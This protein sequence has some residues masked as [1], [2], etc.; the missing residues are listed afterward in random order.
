MYWTVG[1]RVKKAF[2]FR[3][4]AVIR[5]YAMSDELPT[6]R[7]D[8]LAT[9]HIS[10]SSRQ[11]PTAS[12]T[13]LQRDASSSTMLSTVTVTAVSRPIL[14][15]EC[16][17]KRPFKVTAEKFPTFLPS[18]VERIKD[19][20]ALKLAARIERL[21]V[22]VHVLLLRQFLYP[23]LQILCYLKYDPFMKILRS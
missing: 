3:Y 12:E 1:F 20:F 15:V 7:L 18:D 16:K 10:S 9:C 6:K 4:V 5:P 17:M 8:L 2:F 19:T 22:Q 23:K 14:K 11:L 21:P 13:E